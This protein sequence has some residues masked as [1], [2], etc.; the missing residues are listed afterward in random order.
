MGVGGTW[1]NGTGGA[2]W[3]CS[4]SGSGPDCAVSH[5]GTYIGHDWDVARKEG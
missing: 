3:A 1:K 4:V 5:V 2:G